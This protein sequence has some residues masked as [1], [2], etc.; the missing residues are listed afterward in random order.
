MVPAQRPVRDLSE[1]ALDNYRIDP[2]ARIAQAEKLYGMPYDKL[3]PVRQ[4]EVDRKLANAQFM[5]NPSSPSLLRGMLQDRF[6]ALP[7]DAAT[8]AMHNNTLAALEGRNRRQLDIINGLYRK[9]MELMNETNHI[10]ASN[11]EY[12]SGVT[13][14]GNMGQAARHF[15]PPPGQDPIPNVT[16]MDGSALFSN[17]KEERCRDSFRRANN[18]ATQ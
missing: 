3:S 2:A 11:P 16:R 9:E 4:S 10:N 14:E 8:K 15:M 18:I 13:A 1:L 17:S 12:F 5:E 7:G 6:D